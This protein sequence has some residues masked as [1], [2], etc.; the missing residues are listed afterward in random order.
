MESGRKPIR[1]LGVHKQEKS[2]RNVMLQAT[3]SI[4]LRSLF[5]DVLPVRLF[6]DKVDHTNDVQIAGCVMHAKIGSG[7]GS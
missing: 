7:I 3:Y 6:G 5:S 4:K 2:T 1:A